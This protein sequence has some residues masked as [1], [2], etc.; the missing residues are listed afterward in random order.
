MTTHGHGYLCWG[1]GQLPSGD[2]TECQWESCCLYEAAGFGSSSHGFRLLVVGFGIWTTHDLE[3]LAQLLLFKY[4][5]FPLQA[6][7]REQ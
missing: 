5:S 4:S 3:N 6:R 7:L 2:L 1:K